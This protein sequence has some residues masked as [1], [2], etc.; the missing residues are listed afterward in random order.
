M[1]RVS[2]H[3]RRPVRRRQRPASRGVG[4]GEAQPVHAYRR[5]VAQHQVGADAEQRGLPV[6]LVGRAAGQA[7]RSRA[8]R[9]QHAAVGDVLGQLRRARA[10]ASSA[11]PASGSA[12]ITTSAGSASASDSTTRTRSATQRPWAVDVAARSASASAPA[13]TVS[14]S[15]GQQ[16]VDGGGQHRRAGVGADQEAVSWDRCAGRARRRACGRPAVRSATGR[17]GHAGRLALRSYCGQRRAPRAG[18]RRARGRPGY[19]R[20]GAGSV[21]IVSGLGQR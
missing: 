2:R 12:T 10:R 20:R 17:R 11:V 4:R 19:L 7:G 9:R 1:P 6:E 21:R 14:V 5:H 15:L 13:T 16:R 8:P 18:C 3:A